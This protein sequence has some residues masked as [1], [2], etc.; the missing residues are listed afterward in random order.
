MVFC[1]AKGQHFKNY[2]YSARK[3]SFMS[4]NIKKSGGILSLIIQKFISVIIWLYKILS[5]MESYFSSSNKLIPVC[6][7]APIACSLYSPK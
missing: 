3:L 5:I 4:N 6:S 7:P 2:K 1:K